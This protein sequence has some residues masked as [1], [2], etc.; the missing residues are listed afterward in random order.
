MVHP[1]GIPPAFTFIA[2]PRFAT[3]LLA[4]VLDSLVR[5]SRRVDENHCANIPD[6][7]VQRS[8]AGPRRARHSVESHHPE[9]GPARG[10]PLRVRFASVQPAAH[11]WA[12]SPKRANEPSRLLP[13]AKPMLTREWATY[14]PLS[15]ALGRTEVTHRAVGFDRFSS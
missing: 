5:V 15:L 14:R 4:C 2:H 10:Q 13:H 8:P 3:L 11:P 6:S 12:N 7:P 1:R 9:Q